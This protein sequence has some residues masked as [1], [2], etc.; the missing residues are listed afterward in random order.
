GHPDAVPILEAMSR[1]Y[2]KTFRLRKAFDCLTEW[3][4][5]RPD[6]IQG[7]LLRGQTL[8]ML[9]LYPQVLADYQRAIELDPQNPVAREKLGH[10]LSQAK[11]FAEAKEHFEWLQQHKPH[12]PAVRLGLARC[13]RALAKN[14]QAG[15]LLDALLTDSPDHVDALVER[16]KLDLETRQLEQAE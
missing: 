11:L 2:L 4:E 13:Y 5:R 12:D 3:L 10:A 16:G 7:L 15:S 8:E 9:Q 1:G 6:D 14:D